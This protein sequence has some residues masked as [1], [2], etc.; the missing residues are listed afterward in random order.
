MIITRTTE[1]E[2]YLNCPAQFEQ[3]QFNL[4]PFTLFF[5]DI[6]HLAMRYPDIAKEIWKKFR[7]IASSVNKKNKREPKTYDF[8]KNIS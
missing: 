7:L 8:F 6:A 2:S 4:E 3:W 1:L 5:G